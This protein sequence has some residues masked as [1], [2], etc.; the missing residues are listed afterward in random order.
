MTAGPS[1]G[2]ASAYPTFRTPALIC[3][4][5][6]KD[7]FVTLLIILFTFL[8]PFVSSATK[9]RR[10]RSRSQCPSFIMSFHIIFLLQKQR[11]GT[12]ERAFLGMALSQETGCQPEK[13]LS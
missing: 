4:S 11:S 6:P 8:L 10:R 7:V 13:L 9:Y 12:R 3:F 2:P 5:E 1:V